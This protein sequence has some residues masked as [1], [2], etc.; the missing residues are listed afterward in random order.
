MKIV[1]FEEFCKLPN[2]TVFMEFQNA[3]RIQDGYSFQ[4]MVRG[5]VSYDEGKPIDFLEAP[6]LPQIEDGN[7]VTPWGFCRWALYE[8]D[9]KFLVLEKEDCDRLGGWLLDPV[10]ALDDMNVDPLVSIPLE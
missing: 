9:N 5:D 3:G 6:L 4:L 1:G 8:Y 2:G 7:V 10:K